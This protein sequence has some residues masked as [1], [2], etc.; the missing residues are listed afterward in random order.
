MALEPQN[1]RSS[2]EG[3]SSRGRHLPAD[4]AVLEASKASNRPARC[5]LYRPNLVA[6]AVNVAVR[7]RPELV[8]AAAAAVRRRP[9]VTADCRPISYHQA[10]RGRNCVT[11]PFQHR[12]R[13]LPRRLASP[14]TPP[15]WRPPRS[16]EAASF[17]R[18]M[19]SASRSLGDPLSR[20]AYSRMLTIDDCAAFRTRLWVL[21]YK[22]TTNIEASRYLVL[23]SC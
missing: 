12:Q 18:S 3:R 5:S 22:L 2:S 17:H 21:L 14:A 15:A 23:L 13:C 9:D 16:T 8:A 6:A 1:L 19:T 10:R 4:L 20:R 11:R 7:R